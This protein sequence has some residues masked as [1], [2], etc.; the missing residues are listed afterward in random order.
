MKIM[1]CYIRRSRSNGDLKLL[2]CRLAHLSALPAALLLAAL[3]LAQAVANRRAVG[4]KA[5]GSCPQRCWPY[6]YVGEIVFGSVAHDL[7]LHFDH[8]LPH[9]PHLL[10]FIFPY[11]PLGNCLQPFGWQPFCWQLPAPTNGCQQKGVS[12]RHTSFPFS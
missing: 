12:A 6:E 10:S 5:G 4:R 3:L 8:H 1:Q 7:F 11:P 9:F 2:I